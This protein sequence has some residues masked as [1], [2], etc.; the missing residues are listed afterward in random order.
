MTFGKEV[1]SQVREYLSSRGFATVA[2]G[3]GS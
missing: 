1:P 3:L 2:E